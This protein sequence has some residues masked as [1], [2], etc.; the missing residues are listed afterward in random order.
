MSDH[1]A[2]KSREDE[3]ITAVR[4]HMQDNSAPTSRADDNSDDIGSRSTRFQRSLPRM[5][6]EML[7][8]ELSELKASRPLY[9]SLT[10][11][12]LRRLTCIWLKYPCYERSS[13][14]V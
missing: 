12:S 9:Y 10:T 13:V 11:P 5:L 3:T 4:M 14:V 7:R 2:H 8:L 1:E 6:L